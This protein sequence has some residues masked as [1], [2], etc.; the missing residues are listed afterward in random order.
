MIPDD[1]RFAL[2]HW[3]TAGKGYA[4]LGV[5][6]SG[7]TLQDLI[8]VDTEP[9]HTYLATVSGPEAC[10]GDVVVYSAKEFLER[11]YLNSCWLYSQGLGSLQEEGQGEAYLRELRQ[12]AMVG[13]KVTS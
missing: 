9:V 3:D 5:G 4:V 2:I 7:W 12:L 1:A 10:L 13:N 11:V 6:D 8:D